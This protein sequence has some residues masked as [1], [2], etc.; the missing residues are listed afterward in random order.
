MTLSSN[1]QPSGNQ[2]FL[3]VNLMSEG[4]QG[5]H[6]CVGASIVRFKR[7]GSLVTEGCSIDEFEF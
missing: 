4:T 6:Y 3:S 5:S 7:S 2:G 1:R